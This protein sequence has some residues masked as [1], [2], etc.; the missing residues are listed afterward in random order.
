MPRAMNGAATSSSGS[1][2]R[3]GVMPGSDLE[4]QLPVPFRVL[5]L[6]SHLALE[7]AK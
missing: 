6:T 7:G 3:L 2:D 5:K 1:N 4:A